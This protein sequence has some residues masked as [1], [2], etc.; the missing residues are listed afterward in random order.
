ME[1]WRH[2]IE[3]T[4]PSTS[5]NQV[6]TISHNSKIQKVTKLYLGISSEGHIKHIEMQCLEALDDLVAKRVVPYDNL[7]YLY[8]NKAPCAGLL[9]T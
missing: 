3:R 4:V 6:R 8:L 7:I 2:G 9:N 5:T 1:E